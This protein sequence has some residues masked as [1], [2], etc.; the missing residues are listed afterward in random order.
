MTQR[1]ELL[2]G[3]AGGVLAALLAGTATAQENSI[4]ATLSD[5]ERANLRLV[6]RFC[7]AWE[8]MDLSQ[9][10]ATMTADAVYR[11]SQDT[12]P[13]IGHQAL[14]DMMQPWI[15]SSHA[16]TYQVLESFAR[17]PV[18][19]NRRIDIYHSDTNHL[20]WEGVGLFLIDGDLIREWQDF[21]IRIQRGKA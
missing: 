4:Q 20:E 17:G 2:A 1:R 10:T 15:E 21:T 8:A 14:I 18:V 13:V 5:K 7:K 12:P 3:S 9:V 6:D 19:V 16:I 11:Q